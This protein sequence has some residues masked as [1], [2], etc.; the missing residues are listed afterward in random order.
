MLGL[1]EE[2]TPKFV[3]KYMDGATLVRSALS[4]Y[5]EEVVNGDVPKEEHTY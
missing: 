5:A 4:H 1:F 3:K 2:F